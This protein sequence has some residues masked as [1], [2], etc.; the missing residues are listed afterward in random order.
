MA[1][2]CF[3]DLNFASL[4][5]IEVKSV[6][7]ETVQCVCVKDVSRDAKSESNGGVQGCVKAARC[8]IGWFGAHVNSICDEKNLRES[9]DKELKNF[10]I[11]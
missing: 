3:R 6:W 9:F 8:Q 10:L 4:L 2:S 7:Y 5:V 11:V 1:V